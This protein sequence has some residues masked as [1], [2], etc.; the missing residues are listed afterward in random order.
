MKIGILSFFIT[1]I[2]CGCWLSDRKEETHI[3]EARKEATKA[4][5][6]GQVDISYPAPPQTNVN[7]SGNAS[8]IITP[9]TGLV[10]ASK[11]EAK[12]A[13]DSSSTRFSVD[14]M[15][16]Q[17]SPA[18]WALLVMS[19]AGLMVA[20]VFVSKFSA[21]GRAADASIAG[22]LDV[23]RKGIAGMTALIEDADPKSDAAIQARRQRDFLRSTESKLLE[24]K[25]R[26][27]SIFKP[28]TWR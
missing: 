23:A 13:L 25:D 5:S 9:T 18:G 26:K 14:A 22:G 24:R 7:A 6:Q 27:R 17:V 19:M 15:I 21:A 16:S 12:S 4:V 8:V 2:L 20:W 10:M 28:E 3:Q 11:A 1:F